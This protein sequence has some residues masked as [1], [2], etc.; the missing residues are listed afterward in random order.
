MTELFTL[1]LQTLLFRPYVFIFLGMALFA[2][3][4]LLGWRRANT[5]FSMTWVTAFICE[6]SSTRIGVPFGDYFYTGSTAGQELYISNIPFMDSLS[7]TFLLFASYC[8]ALVFLLP[9]QHPGSFGGWRF[10]RG[11]RT[12]WPVVL[13]TTVLFTFIDIVIDPVALRGGRWFLGQI[14]GYPDP[15]IYF[16]VPLANFLGWAVVGSVALTIYGRIDQRCWADSPP[17]REVV[18]TDLLLGVGLYYAVL[19]FNL[20][21]TFWIGERLLGLVGCFLYVPISIL[22]MLRVFGG[23]A[24]FNTSTPTRS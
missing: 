22:L 23:L 11:E 7:F 6:F 2:A 17:P 10:Q 13:L 16:G 24:T 1:L 20:G 3:S 19:A 18:K 8:M 5:L 12:S 9:A 21:V 4:R 14:Y 15:G